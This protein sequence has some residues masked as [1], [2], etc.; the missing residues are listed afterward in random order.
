MLKPQN[1][2]FN[3]KKIKQGIPCLSWVYSF[4]LIVQ[5]IVWVFR[6]L[7]AHG[8]DRGGGWLELGRDSDAAHIAVAKVREEAIHLQHSVKYS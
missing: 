8:M 4:V 5:V 6:F 1:I 7:K 3:I 2:A